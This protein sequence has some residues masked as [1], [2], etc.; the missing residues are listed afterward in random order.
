MPYAMIIRVALAALLL[1]TGFPSSSS[2]NDLPL[3]TWERGR[4][5]EVFV[6]FADVKN[7]DW[8]VQLERE[9]AEPLPFKRSQ[10]SSAGNLVFVGFI[11]NNYPSGSY[12]V[13]VQRGQD[14]KQILAAVNVIEAISYNLTKIPR[15]MVLV[16][17]LFGFLVATFSNLR[18]RKYANAL[19]LPN[20]NSDSSWLR[21]SKMFINS[22]R[23]SVFK[24]FLRV[25]QTFLFRANRYLP[26]LMPIVGLG[27]VAFITTKVQDF[28]SIGQTPTSY[29]VLI[30]I[31]GLLDLSSA[32]MSSI[33]FWVLQLGLG[34][35]TSFRD[36]WVILTIGLS[37]LL[38]GL[39]R[40]IY[41]GVSELSRNRNSF[42]N[43]GNWIFLP[44]AVCLAM[45]YLSSKMVD[46]VLLSVSNERK[47]DFYILAFLAIASLFRSFI[48]RR[49]RNLDLQNISDSEEEI[50]EIARVASP[51]TATLTALLIFGFG[52]MWSEDFQKAV[53]LGIAF[54]LPFF[55]LSIRLNEIHVPKLATVPRNMFLESSVVAAL[56]AA[57]YAPI[58]NLPLLS[59]DRGFAYMFASALPILAHS[60]YSAISDYAERVATGASE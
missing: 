34:N 18:I 45:F 42:K 54:S 12:V 60:L 26:T 51:T 37:W 35:V 1:L 21:L 58:S 43:S 33:I 25:D 31:V 40:N 44:T 48:E 23:E 27:S 29:F 2:A 3:L 32:V 19:Y 41:S 55:L 5:Q 9:G 39:M 13:T 7:D 47:I 11:P 57:V 46:S 56:T 10:A 24:Y 28:G 38:P 59:D 36:L 6:G 4:Q 52:Y 16:L 22:F 30:A 17:S 49:Q 14:D 15:D 20:L 53:L 8:K 50:F